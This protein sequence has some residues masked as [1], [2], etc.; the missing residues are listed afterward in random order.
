MKRSQYIT[1]VILATMLLGAC[2]SSSSPA[3]KQEKQ[4]DQGM[5]PTNYAEVDDNFRHDTLLIQTTF[6]MGDGSFVM[7][8]GNVNPTFEGIRLYRYNV[9]PD[10]TG[11]ILAASSPG[12]DSWTMLPTF[13]PITDQA[14][15]HLI[16]ANFGERESWGQKLIRMDAGFT[17]LGF[18]DVAYPERMQEGDSS[19]VKRKNIGPYTRLSVKGD[20][21][22]FTFACDSLFLY[23]D[24]AGGFDLL[25]PAAS[26]RYT[27][28]PS[29]GLVIWRDGRPRPVKQ[30]S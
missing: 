3:A 27:W 24:M 1:T 14:G 25:V 13:F 29:T 18:L 11:E 23:D 5:A 12:Y 10:S 21:A 17:D 16:L 9:R 6:D 22:V 15:E 28:H 20:S 2:G 19:Y 30:L 8:A 4:V 7:V 26:V